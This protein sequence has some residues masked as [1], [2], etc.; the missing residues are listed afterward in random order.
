MRSETQHSS[1]AA[2]G[3]VLIPTARCAL[4][5]PVYSQQQQQQ[6]QHRGVIHIDLSQ[7]EQSRARFDTDVEARMGRAY[8]GIRPKE[9]ADTARY[10][11]RGSI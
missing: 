10:T 4:G 1:S 5:V 9:R 7:E 2:L 11:H 3:I 8:G 6:Q